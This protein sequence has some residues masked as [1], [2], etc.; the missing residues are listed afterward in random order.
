MLVGRI[1]FRNGP[2]HGRRKLETIFDSVVRVEL[3]R[4]DRRHHQANQHER[5]SHNPFHLFS[6]TTGSFRCF[7]RET[8]LPN[9]DPSREMILFC[10][11][12]S[13]SIPRTPSSTNSSIC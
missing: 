4:E 12:I 13:T 6:S 5:E 1:R 9:A 11:S 7:Q 10:L 8:W 2:P 3:L